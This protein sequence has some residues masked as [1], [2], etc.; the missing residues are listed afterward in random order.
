[1]KAQTPK[2]FNTKLSIGILFLPLSAIYWFISSI[3]RV[4][5][6]PYK[7]KAKVICVGNITLGGV[8]KTPLVIK[9]IEILLQ[10]KV[11][12]GVLSRGYRGAL[13]STTP[14]LVNKKHTAS[15]V[16]DEVFMIF[17]RFNGKVPTCICTNRANGAKVLEDKV[18]IIIMDDGLQNY[19][20][21]KDKS[22]LV[23]DGGQTVGN[24][25]IFPAGPLRETLGCGIK[26]ASSIVIMRKINQAF[27]KKLLHYHLPVFNAKTVAKNLE[28][29]AGKSVIAFA[30]IGNPQKFYDTLHGA[31]IKIKRSFEFPDHHQYSDEDFE[32]I[33][34]SAGNLPVLTTTKDY[35]KI[36]PK[37]QKKITPIEIDLCI[38]E[39]KDFFDI[40]LK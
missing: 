32:K 17:Q 29:F 18:D 19:T 40:I 26:K 16:G 10:K 37:Y 38:N 36:P 23:F 39:E 15:D 25:F 22:I 34:K 14:V 12:V 2:Y 4:F 1:M 30:G 3:K 20:L 5:S 9:I 13:S 24:G 6:K 35:V 28:N 33:L 31:K 11:R 21:A 8:G 7:S 27:E